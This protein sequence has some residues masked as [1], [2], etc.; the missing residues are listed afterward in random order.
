MD[1]QD[2][3]GALA[4]GGRFRV[5]SSFLEITNPAGQTAATISASEITAMRRVGTTVVV[6]R[7]TGGD[8]TVT[9]ATAEDANRLENA[10]RS[11]IPSG[12]GGGI[13]RYLK[14]GCL[15]TL[16][17]I[18]VLVVIGI[19]AS[20]AS[21]DD[22]DVDDT[23]G[24]ATRTPATTSQAKSPATETALV[25]K[26]SATPI[27][28]TPTMATE[29]ADT[30]TPTT[31]PTATPEPS[32]TPTAE[33]SPTPA[34][35][36]ASRVNPIPRG[37]TAT[38]EEWELQVLDAVRG[39]EA[40]NRLL[41]ANQFNEPAPAGYEY[42]LVSVRAKYIG[43][44]NEAQRID[45]SSFHATGDARVKHEFA[46]VVEPEPELQAEL[47]PGGEATGWLAVLVREAETNL[48]LVFEPLFSFEDGDELF[49]AVDDGATVAPITE[50]LAD[51]ND[52]GFDRADPVPLGEHIVGDTWEI[53]VIE[54]VR[55]DEALRRVKEENQFNEDPAA[56]M[57]YV[58]VHIG[59]R[60][61]EPEEAPEL[62][63]EFAFKL[64]GDAGR[65]YDNP[66]IV[67]PEPDLGYTV[68]TGGA[69]DGW[70]TLQCATG[71]QNLRVVYEPLFSLTGDPRYFAI[72]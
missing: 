21:D 29:S 15:G 45:F 56:G 62:I 66:S 61:V 3:S 18:V 26:P 28:V 72:E 39:E 7:R 38:T 70:V 33:L 23:A 52:H 17:L 34:S 46:S 13:G 44:S 64:T 50:R 48:Q 1:S 68:Y 47:F 63:D 5:T 14:W 9:A 40:H 19:V 30:P 59:A 53:W 43:T 16:G 6:L 32:A 54:S 57:E 55:G 35:A 31:E 20:L 36:G 69:V 12:T 71:E 24:A 58:L 60:N 10:L 67:D 8:V 11:S 41:E 2:V 25:A 42:V 49:L 22:D 51:Q 37:S 27:A 65:I 4:S